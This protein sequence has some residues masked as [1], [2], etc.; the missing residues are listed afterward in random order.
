MLTFDL[1]DRG[2]VNVLWANR[3]NGLQHHGFLKALIR[4][5]LIWTKEF[6]IKLY[7]YIISLV[8]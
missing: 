3:I 8:F 7:I 6:N 4:G 1:G 5:V 2:H